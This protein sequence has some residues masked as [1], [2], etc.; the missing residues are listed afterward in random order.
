MSGKVILLLCEF[1]FSCSCI[2]GQKSPVQVASIFVGANSTRCSLH[3]GFASDTSAARSVVRLAFSC[4]CLQGKSMK[5]HPR[6]AAPSSTVPMSLPRPMHLGSRCCNLL[7]H[8]SMQPAAPRIRP[9]PGCGSTTKKLTQNQ[10][11][12]HKI[13]QIHTN[14][15]RFFCRQRQH[16]FV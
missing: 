14:S 5:N 11:N 4:S 6:F 1:L 10:K 2:R 12:P 13:R 16:Q 8:K 7:Q 9:G 3:R 15:G